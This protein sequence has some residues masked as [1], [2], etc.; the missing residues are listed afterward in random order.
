M[1]RL[2]VKANSVTEV[3][4]MRR[5]SSI[6][7]SGAG[8]Q[9]MADGGAIGPPLDTTSTFAPW[10]CRAHGRARSSRRPGSRRSWACRPARTPLHPGAK[11]VAQQAEV[12]AV[13]LGRVGPAR[14]ARMDGRD[15]LASLSYSLSPGQGSTSSAAPRRGLRRCPARSARWRLQRA[16]DDGVEGM[17]RSRQ[18]SPSRPA[19]A[20][21]QFAELVVV[22]APKVACP[23][24]TR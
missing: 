13:H 4:R 22:V 5:F 14:A 17:P 10:C 2:G 16:G 11:A 7:V 8:A 1:W 20:V 23:W 6:V 12:V 24:R 3:L 21:P 9:H 19:L 18:Y 15:R